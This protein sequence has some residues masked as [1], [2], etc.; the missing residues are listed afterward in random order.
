MLGYTLIVAT[1]AI[2]QIGQ[3]QSIGV[4]QLCALKLFL[5]QSCLLFRMLHF[6]AVIGQ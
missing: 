6:M 1:L 4:G 3:N 2:S 5:L